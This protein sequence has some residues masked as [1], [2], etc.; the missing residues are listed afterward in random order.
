MT[1]AEFMVPSLWDAVILLALAF[2]IHVLVEL[3]REIKR[4]N[5]PSEDEAVIDIQINDYNQ[6]VD[7]KAQRV[8]DDQRK[9]AS[10]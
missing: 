5:Q 4:L 9:G 7:G 1:V 8:Q 6:G 2:A 3:A 10:V